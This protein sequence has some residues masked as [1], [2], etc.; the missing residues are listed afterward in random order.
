MK[1]SRVWSENDKDMYYSTE[2]DFQ[3]KASD[4]KNILM[5]FTSLTDSIG[6][7][8][9]INDIVENLTKTGEKLEVVGSSE[10]S[11]IVLKDGKQCHDMP[12]KF[13]IIGNKFQMRT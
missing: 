8:I 4:P 2:K 6:G 11:I 1:K 3:I 9:Y 10:N 13:K 12:L 7:E 5:E